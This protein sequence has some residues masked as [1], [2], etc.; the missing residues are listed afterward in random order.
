MLLLET[1]NLMD[2]PVF[3]SLFL[4]LYMLTLFYIAFF[5]SFENSG[6]SKKTK[7]KAIKAAVIV[8]AFN[9]EDTIVGTI[10]SLLNLRYPKRML[11]IYVVNDGSK[12]KTWEILQRF[13]NDKRIRLIRKE[14]GGKASALNLAFENLDKDTE[15][16]GVLDADS[17]VDKDALHYIVSEFQERPE[18]AAVTPAIKIHKPDSL[19]RFLQNAEYSLS[20]Y[21]RK[22]F[23][24]LSMIFIIPGPFSFYRKDALDALGKWKHAHG[25]EDLEMGLRFQEHGLKVGNTTKAIVY[26]VSPRTIKQLYRQRLRWTYGFLNNAIDYKHLFFNR[27][28]GA[29]GLL[30]LP[31]SVL[32][33][34]LAVYIFFYGL[35]SLFNAFYLRFEHWMEFGFDFKFNFDM[36][37]FLPSI[38]TWLAVIS[39]VFAVL[40]SFIGDRSTGTRSLKVKD[41]LSYITLY[42]FVA[43]LWIFSSLLKT[44]RGSNVKWTKVNK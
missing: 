36:F 22:A 34:L 28:R 25:T 41:L 33:L 3:I 24:N 6:K 35:Y 18:L 30:A 14:N 27:K 12:D 15:I 4:S 43:P 8:P 9:E 31:V 11:K 17:F 13:K 32:S 44:I 16:V 38:I 39:I 2:L 5:E 19:I 42:G 40:A 26:T 29:V 7:V 21:L 23:D 37:Y 1:M 20:V 10:R